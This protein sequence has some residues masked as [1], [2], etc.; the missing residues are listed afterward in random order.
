VRLL[1]RLVA[2]LAAASVV[3]TLFFIPGFASAGGLR[4]LVTSGA[5]GV[6]T[7]VG[8][9]I[10]LVMGP[11]AA[12]Q[13]WRFRETGRRAG[14]IMFGYGLAYYLIGALGLRSSEASIGQIVIAAT[15]FALPLIVLLSP[16]TRLLFAAVKSNTNR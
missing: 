1:V 10:T 12:V 6:L 4:A 14:I 7:I 2:V 9:V 16:R 13:L 15:I 3:L 11:I 5:L 8:W